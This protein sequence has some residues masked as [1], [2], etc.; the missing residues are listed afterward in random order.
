MTVFSN[1][2]SNCNH[3]SFPSINVVPLYYNGMEF[4][5]EITQS[6][7]SHYKDDIVFIVQD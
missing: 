7:V 1:F 4:M 5:I 3:V 6:I 2:L